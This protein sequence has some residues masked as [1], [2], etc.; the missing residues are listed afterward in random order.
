[1]EILRDLNREQKEAVM[2]TDGPLLILAGAGSGKTRVLTY[3]YA[4]LVKEKGIDLD[5]ILAI[6]FTNKAAQEMKNRIAAILHV[7]PRQTWIS[8]FHAACVRI[9]RADGEKVGIR[10]GFTIA[11]GADQSALMRKCIRD[12][13]YIEKDY[14]VA[15]VMAQISNAKNRLVEVE[16]F[17]SEAKG[18][19]EEKIGRLF[20]RYQK[21]LRESGTLDFDDLLLM[22]VKLLRNHRDILEKYQDQFRYIMVDEYQDTN[23]AQYVL[24]NLLAKKNRNICVVGDD[25]QSIYRWR[26]ADI[27]NI[28]NFEKDYPEAKVIKL[29]QNYRSTKTILEA[30]NHLVRNN[31]SQK[32][33]KL[34]TENDDGEKIVCRKLSGEQEEAW[35]IAD[36]ID[37]LHGEENYGY[38]AFAVLYRTNAQSRVIEE[39]LMKRK[40]PYVIVGGTKFY[41]RKEVKDIIAYLRVVQNLSDSMSLE[42][43]INVPKR[44]I[45]AATVEKIRAYCIDHRLDLFAGMRNIAQVPGISARGSKEIS[46]LVD[47][48]TR[49]HNRKEEV[50]VSEIIEKIITETGY[51]RE[52]ET[53]DTPE[54]ISRK[55]NIL[56]FLGVAKEYEKNEPEQTLEDF[57]AAI[58]LIS[59]VDTMP[60]EDAVVLMTLHSAKGLEF[61]VVFLAGLEEGIFPHSRSLESED[62]M[63][64]ER[65]LCYVGIT[66]A[67]KMLFL[68]YTA[69]RNLYGQPVMNMPSRFIR[70]VPHELLDWDKSGQSDRVSIQKHTR[71]SAERRTTH[72]TSEGHD[73]HQNAESPIPEYGLGEKIRHRTFG[74]GTIIGKK[75]IREDVE[76]VITF[77]K[78]GIK[79]L[80]AKYAP[81]EKMER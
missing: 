7:H 24:V 35:F 80:S 33:K 28:L 60:E 59:E 21:Y 68:T 52:L 6:T 63:E 26:G 46:R 78:A 69:R 12:L 76:L 32:D 71:P 4:Y 14:P 57:L 20:Q 54:S 45:G 48:L 49:L 74:Q 72:G 2:H 70:E 81:L 1:M 3:R 41:Q 55:E 25:N 75:E 5:D 61:P 43:I 56:E 67:E 16:D 58:A 79:K 38:S 34:W 36:S 22:A 39:V 37:A 27:T 65:R 29:E 66:R 50:N 10:K 51:I 77:E 19:R 11:D 9:L 13:N 40:I 18:F 73:G 8:T 15:S 64:E 30:A 62:E 53:E 44:G 31:I 47:L 42:R 17:V 23:Y